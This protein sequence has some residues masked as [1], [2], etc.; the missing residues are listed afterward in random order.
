MATVIRQPGLRSQT[1][2]TSGSVQYL[3][4]YDGPYAG[5][6]DV[7]LQEKKA[8]PNE[9][10]IPMGLEVFQGVSKLVA[11]QV[12]G[13]DEAW[14]S[15]M[16]FIVDDGAG[17]QLFNV[18]E[19]KTLNSFVQ[20]LLGQWR[21]FYM[22][23]INSSAGNWIMELEHPASC[24][25][26]VFCPWAGPAMTV[27]MPTGEVLGH[28]KHAGRE[29]CGSWLGPSYYFEVYNYE[30]N[31]VYKVEGPAGYPWECTRDSVAVFK[32]LKEGSQSE[33]AQEV[34]EITHTWRGCCGG[35][36]S[37]CISGEPDFVTIS[38]PESLSAEDKA[39]FLGLLFSVMHAYL[40]VQ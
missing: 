35:I 27:R 14:W 15:N 4:G 39:L 17:N 31:L 36:C 18:K 10:P 33:P 19:I 12:V 23:V 20:A 8:R 2:G 24:G 37:C 22:K 25:C 32:I 38:F 29:T 13:E 3:G 1:S 16:E 7:F 26:P 21:S 9:V 40:E 30:G 11:H 28:I 5:E 6:E 34:G